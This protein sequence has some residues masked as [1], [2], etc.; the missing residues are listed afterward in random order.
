VKPLPDEDVVRIPRLRTERLLLRAP[1]IEDF[2]A[3]FE[4]AS[5]PESR[6]YIGGALDRREAWRRFLQMGG[7]WG[8]LPGLGW[9]SVEGPDRA[10]V[11]C[12][13]VFRRETGEEIEIGWALHRGHRRHGYATEAA[14][15]A[16]GYAVHVA[17]APR[18]IAYIG[19]E[20][21]PSMGV[22]ERIGM[23][24]VGRVEFYGEP[25]WLYDHLPR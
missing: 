14:K 21:T 11:G 24:R 7:N 2:D 8:L 22:A 5:D 10:W 4:D 16:L 13:G 25:H 1:R 6:Q 17:G 20:N 18:V 3:F 23:K 9:W 12:V 15:A 19:P